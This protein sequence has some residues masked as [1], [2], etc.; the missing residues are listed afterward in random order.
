MPKTLE[1]I[2]RKL[3]K[4]VKRIVN[5]ETANLD[6]L[7]ACTLAEDIFGEL[8]EEYGMRAGELAD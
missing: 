4:K 7:T 5:E 8:A 1:E 3:E 6:E 2:G